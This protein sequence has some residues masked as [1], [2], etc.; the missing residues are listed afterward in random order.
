MLTLFILSFLVV[1]CVNSLYTSV[2][3]QII[4]VIGN[5][6]IVCHCWSRFGSVKKA[7]NRDVLRDDTDCPTGNNMKFIENK[8]HH[9]AFSL[10]VPS[11]DQTYLTLDGIFINY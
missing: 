3:V 1:P 11:L 8:I 4:L 9:V 6:R 10:T 7:S 5:A 2:K